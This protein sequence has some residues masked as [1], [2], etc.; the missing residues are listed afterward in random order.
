[1]DIEEVTGC[2]KCNNFSA[3]SHFGDGKCHVCKGR[4]RVHKIGRPGYQAKC[5]KCKGSGRC[6]NCRGRGII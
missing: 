5:P 2:R 6:A 4:G 3:L 1:M